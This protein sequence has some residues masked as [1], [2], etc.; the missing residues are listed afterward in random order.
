LRVKRPVLRVADYKHS[1][2]HRYV[3]EGYREAGKRRRLFFRNKTDALVAL[4]RIQ[5]RQRMEGEAGLRISDA[6]RAEAAEAQRRLEPHGRTIREAVDFFLKHLKDSERSISV[7]ALKVEYMAAKAKARLSVRYQE[8]LRYRLARFEDSFGQQPVRT[9]TARTIED[10]LHG[11]ELSAHSIN[12]YRGCVGALF[13]YAQRRNYVDVNPVGAIDKIKLLDEPPPI[14][15]PRELEVLLGN[16]SPE[17]LPLLALGAFSG[18]RSSELMRLSW[19]DIDLARGFVNVAAAKAKSAQRRL[20]A[21]SDNLREWLSPYA[22]RTG[23]LWK[24]SRWAYHA[25]IEALCERVGLGRWP[26]NG[27]RHSYGS[28]HMARHANAPMTAINMG[29]ISPAMTFAHYREIVTP[30][31]AEAFWNIRPPRQAEN[32][33]PIKSIG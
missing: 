8:D 33:L 31:A 9:L 1:L 26:R 16:A 12:N 27:L 14:L 11:L 29:H 30:E 10:W 32:I 20:I 7:S 28:Y 4:R 22:G 15:T 6:L 24:R 5:I 19:D 18:L 21:M 2:T 17:L 23:A 25:E 3:I 13:S